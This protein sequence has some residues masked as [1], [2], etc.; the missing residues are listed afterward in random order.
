MRTAVLVPKHFGMICCTNRSCSNPKKQAKSNQ[1]DRRIESD[2]DH[3]MNQRPLRKERGVENEG[4]SRLSIK[5]E[6]AVGRAS[7]RM[8]TPFQ[9]DTGDRCPL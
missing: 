2:F 5:L 8:A 9:K 3:L 7:R 4:A 6:E 1:T